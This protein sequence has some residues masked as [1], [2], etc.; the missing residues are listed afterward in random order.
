M[1]T[2]DEL[3]AQVV[4]L[5]ANDDVASIR[6]KLT[7]IPG[8]Q[9]AIVVPLENR[10]L[11]SPVAARLVARMAEDM[12][13]DLAVVSGDV[14]VRRLISD[15]GLLVFRTVNGYKAHIKRQS[16]ALG[17]LGAVLYD[18]RMRADRTFGVILLLA[19]IAVGGG[20][21]YTLIPEARVAL[22]PVSEQVSD[23]IVMKADPTVKKVNYESHVIPSRMVYIP[24]EASVQVP[25][26]GKKQMP[27]AKAEGQ[28]TF[29]NRTADVVV[30]P[31]GTVVRTV[32]NV[33]FLTTSEVKLNAGQGS[34]VRADVI[35]AEP[36]ARGNLDRGKISK[37]EG[38]LDAKV[39][40]FNEEAISGGGARE[41]EV[42]TASDRERARTALMDKLNKDALA[43]L[44]AERKPEERLPA[45]A[46]NFTILEET[47]DKREGEQGKTLNLKM[48]ARAAGTMFSDKDVRDLVAQVWQPKTRPGY[49]V[50]PGAYEILPAEVLKVDGEVINFVVRVQGW[51]VARVSED[52]VREN[53]R[54]KTVDEAHSY[55]IQS[56]NLAKDP[57]IE[58]KPGW[59]TR[60][61]RV[62]VV[63]EGAWKNASMAGQGGQ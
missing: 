60:A 9:A 23:V 3:I 45:Q 53:V 38:E 47:Y 57:K 25:T 51:A 29:T 7:T 59:A 33:R 4:F 58:I 43:K 36:G 12:A 11:R 35:A 62:N 10:S 19:L 8:N 26:S 41:V 52:L 14:A 55:L 32:D 61:L 27:N 49:Q 13:L 2:D 28:V 15:E 39:A 1:P 20:A 37:V 30:I 54:W 31:E 50:P 22:E 5:D 56:L 18:L 42:V 63:V 6:A 21:A 40:V 44:E 48:S 17:R 24:V 34:T 16:A 46:I